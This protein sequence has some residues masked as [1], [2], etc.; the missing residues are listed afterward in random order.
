MYNPQAKLR[1]RIWNWRTNFLP[2]NFTSFSD[3]LVLWHMLRQLLLLTIWN[4]SH[5][6]I[7]IEFQMMWKKVVIQ[8]CRIVQQQLSMAH[9]DRFPWLDELIQGDCTFQAGNTLDPFC[10]QPVSLSALSRGGSHVLSHYILPWAVH[11]S[12]LLNKTQFCLR[13]QCSTIE[14]ML[15]YPHK[16]KKAFGSIDHQVSLH[17]LNNI[18]IGRKTNDWFESYFTDPRQYVLVDDEVMM[19][20]VMIN[21]NWRASSSPFLIRTI[22]VPYICTYFQ[23]RLFS[24]DTTMLYLGYE[25]SSLSELSFDLNN[26]RFCM[27]QN[28]VS[29]IIHEIWSKEINGPCKVTLGN[30]AISVSSKVSLES[31]CTYYQKIRNM[32]VK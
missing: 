2:Q 15:H 21:Q 1:E 11:P 27:G 22:Y 18:E 14:C 19:D 16:H 23:Q 4:Q 25:H 5:W 3:T 30:Q 29:V 10:Y 17:K 12:Y 7:L 28:Q 24:D 20:G 32:W 8:K 9:S 6:M 31:S 26:V 13:P